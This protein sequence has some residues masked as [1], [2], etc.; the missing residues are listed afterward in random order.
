MADEDWVIV[1]NEYE[2]EGA[3]KEAI[4]AEL[5]DLSSSVE[6]A[7]KVTTAR[8]YSFKRSPKISPY[9]YAMVVGPF[10]YF[11]K[12]IDGFPPMRIYARKSLKESIREEQMFHVTREG[13]KFYE[14][15]FQT[16]YPFNKYDQV[17]VPEHNWGAMENVGCVTY[18]E[19]YLF[20]G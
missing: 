20:R 10:D 19:N 8:A 15:F 2:E 14:K 5:N 12:I 9:L 11:E 3:D 7:D 16:K 6:C 4:I 13:I 18:N 17:F 1:S